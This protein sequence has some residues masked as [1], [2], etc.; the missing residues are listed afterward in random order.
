MK[1]GKLYQAQTNLYIDGY[2][3]R[4]TLLQ[5]SIVLLVSENNQEFR[6][7]WGDEV[8]SVSKDT[9]I[10]NIPHEEFFKE[11]INEEGQTL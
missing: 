4:T 3:Y 8:M 9:L 1:Q 10:Y 11:V 2:D 6:V 5:G 7:I